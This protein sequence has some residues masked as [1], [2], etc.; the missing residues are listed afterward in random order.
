MDAMVWGITEL[1]QPQAM[2]LMLP[3]RLRGFKLLIIINFEKFS[4][5]N[6]NNSQLATQNLTHN[7]P[8][9]FYFSRSN[10]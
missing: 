1:S 9:V 10:A 7:Y 6:K 8:Q 2:G 3:K 5:M 4:K